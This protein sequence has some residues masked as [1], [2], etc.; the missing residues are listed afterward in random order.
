MKCKKSTA[1]E[2][3]MDCREW[4]RLAADRDGGRKKRQKTIA[5]AEEISADQNTEN[6]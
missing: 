1:T 6:D 5:V 2:V 4:F 3:E